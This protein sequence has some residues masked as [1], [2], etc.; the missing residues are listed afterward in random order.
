MQADGV[1]WTEV[2]PVSAVDN[3]VTVYRMTPEDVE[4]LLAAKYGGKLN[5]VNQAKLA[6]QNEKRAKMA[7]RMLA[8]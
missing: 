5:A 1:R 7:E 3:G 2:V 6:K 4:K 8:V